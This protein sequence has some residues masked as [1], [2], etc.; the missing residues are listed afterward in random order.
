MVRPR[1]LLRNKPL[2]A[3]LE[4]PVLD[5]RKTYPTYRQRRVINPDTTLDR[6]RVVWVGKMACLCPLDLLDILHGLEIS[7]VIAGARVGFLPTS[8]PQIG[9]THVV[10]VRN[11]YRRYVANRIPK[12]PPE[13]QPRRIM[14]V[15]V[16]HLVPGEKQKVGLYLLDVL[17]YVRLWYI[18]AVRRVN[19]IARK[20]KHNNHILVHRVLFNRPRIERIFAVRHAILNVLRR[21]PLLN[22][23]V[24]RPAILDYLCFGYLLPFSAFL[25]FQPHFPL[26]TLFQ[27][28]QLRRQLHN[29]FVHRIKRKAYHLVP[30]NL[31]H[32]KARPDPLRL[33]PLRRLRLHHTGNDTNYNNPQQHTDYPHTNS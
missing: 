8:A 10:I 14:P 25:D 31:R 32:T 19:R 3:R 9:L 33:R 6:R 12:I 1:S 28:I 30:R 5:N 17:N 13:L 4:L 24:C 18:S 27:W 29:I 20:S 11:R 16:V 26:L 22:T 21:I 7:P 23:E 2:R 15:M